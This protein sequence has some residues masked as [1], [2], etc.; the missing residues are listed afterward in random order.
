MDYLTQ[1]CEPEESEFINLRGVKFKD[2]IIFIEETDKGVKLRA[3]GREFNA[4]FDV[5]RNKWICY[6]P[7]PSGFKSAY[8]KKFSEDFD[9]EYKVH[10]D[11]VTPNTTIFTFA[12]TGG[13]LRDGEIHWECRYSHAS[14]F[15]QEFVEA[16]KNSFNI[17]IQGLPMT[18]LREE[19]YQVIHLVHE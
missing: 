13:Y 16:I 12:D 3:T 9:S 5:A 6:N 19:E 7:T 8:K 2:R 18:L 11:Q 4:D 15:P 10:I 14:T 1:V 17:N